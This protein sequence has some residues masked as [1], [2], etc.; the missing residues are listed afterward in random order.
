[1][2]GSE[3]AMTEHIGKDGPFER[4]YLM[5]DRPQSNTN[6]LNMGGLGLGRQMSAIGRPAM[7]SD[8]GGLRRHRS[9]N[10]PIGG[11]MRDRTTEMKH[12]YGQ[13]FDLTAFDN[14]Q[15]DPALNQSNALA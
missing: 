2:A 13:T 12:V 4:N 7:S 1:M 14:D 8:V 9:S 10:K 15:T 11:K 5:Q 3:V 6:S